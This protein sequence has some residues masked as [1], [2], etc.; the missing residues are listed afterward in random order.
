LQKVGFDYGC[1]PKNNATLVSFSMGKDSIATFLEV[2]DHFENVVPFYLEGV[3]ELEFVENNLAYYEQK[4]GRHI[5]RLPQPAFYGMLNNLLYQPPIEARHRLIWSWQLPHHTHDELHDIVCQIEGLDPLTTYTGIGLK[6]ADSIQR[7]TSLSRNGLVTHSKKKYYPIAQYNKQDVLD[8]VA[9]AGWKLPTD[10]KYMKDSFDGFQIRY[11]L[12]IR[13]H[14]PA[15]Y[16]KIL[17]WFP[18]VELEIYR[19]ERSLR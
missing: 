11:L 3:P 9:S 18:L 12:P 16:Q 19:Y 17:E 15:D 6:Y 10:Y 1:L 13:D 7:R 5:I 2:R 8:K 14:F 4:I